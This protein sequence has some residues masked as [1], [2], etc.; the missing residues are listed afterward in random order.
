MCPLYLKRNAFTTQILFF[1]PVFP[2]F[3]GGKKTPFRVF[4]ERIQ[5]EFAYTSLFEKDTKTHFEK[6]TPNNLIKGSLNYWY[7]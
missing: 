7:F 4:F 1:F 2:Y 6:V 5:V 3:L